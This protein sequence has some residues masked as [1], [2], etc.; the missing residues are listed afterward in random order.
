M[1]NHD[2]PILGD[3]AEKL[4]ACNQKL[5]E[6][7]IDTVIR[8]PRIVVIGDQS[9]G[10]S[11]LLEVISSIF[12]PKSAECCT[13]CPLE[14][15]M[16]NAI[17][18]DTSWSCTIYVE[19]NFT[20]DSTQKRLTKNNPY[21]PWQP[22]VDPQTIAVGSTQ[23]R[24]KLDD[25]INKAQRVVLNP[26][27]D[28]EELLSGQYP[29]TE[30]ERFSPNTIR[31]DIS[32]PGWSNLSF[33]D[34]PGVISHAGKGQPE[35]Y[36]K[37]VEN[38]ARAYAR[39]E[40]NIILLTLPLNHHEDNSNS[41]R[42]T[43]K[44][45][46]HKR[47]IA[48]FTKPDLASQD[49]L[50]RCLKK[51]FGEEVDEEFGYGQHIVML[52]GQNEDD[53][54]KQN[55]WEALP[56]EIQAS[57]GVANLID[58]I[59]GM[60]FEQT[61]KSL[62]EN[63]ISIRE[64]LTKIGQ[65]LQTLP[66][67][68]DAA[69]LPWQLREQFMA[70]ENHIKVLFTYGTP[71]RQSLKSKMNKFSAD[72]NRDKPTLKYKTEQEAKASEDAQSILREASASPVLELEDEEEE[73]DE[74]DKKSP[75][76]LSQADQ[77]AYRFSLDEIYKLNNRFSTSNVP[78]V[79]EPRAVEEMNRMSVQFWD[80]AV[81]EFG[82]NV[83][84]L[85]VAQVQKCINDTFSGQRHLPL[86]PAVTEIIEQYVNMILQDQK[87]ALDEKC[88][89]EKD[90]PFTLN[91][92]GLQL[93]E[94]SILKERLQTRK[95]VRLALEHAE[96]KAEHV[97][98]KGKLKL[99]DENDLDD[100]EYDPEIRMSAK[101]AAYY[102][103]AS[104]RFVDSVCQYVLAYLIPKLHKDMTP[105]VLRKLGLGDMQNANQERITDLMMEDPGREQE[106][107]RLLREQSNL[108]SG[109]EYITEVLDSIALGTQ[110]QQANGAD[111]TIQDAEQVAV[112]ETPEISP[113]KRKANGNTHAE[114]SQTPT[115]KPKQEKLNGTA[116]TGARQ[117]RMASRPKSSEPDDDVQM[118]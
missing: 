47:T 90:V 21:G 103:L 101:S 118:L 51:Y 48:V 83:E 31:F 64:R 102:E 38:L 7:R 98:Q 22:A 14:I 59:R 25:L 46:V 100:D 81:A 30:L 45:G 41:Y 105:F 113:N 40:N 78:G 15:N 93:K 11:S 58:R 65:Q 19:E 70:F 20:Y 61:R 26:G 110:H 28:I 114:A 39:D 109:H 71:S 62:P 55:V 56:Q 33:V 66:P 92:Q 4:I 108:K 2:V 95:Q 63:L 53:F 91:N 43:E 67:P 23:D 89:V 77:R 36:V 88:A 68:P 116:R 69:A 16:S 94:Q 107:R 79:I 17:N 57:L 115:K 84:K 76:K 9:T 49:Q 97:G 73:E 37:L 54:F 29:A 104:T 80:K 32:A 60:L 42:I 34:L 27:H 82:Q 87:L 18:G 24:T 8:L 44:A 85:V 75:R 117:T 6:L 3:A 52:G 13:R 74:V 35:Y 112:P 111:L 106:R 99:K 86:F 96:Q 12:L 72:V 10:K 5:Q 50:D 1:S